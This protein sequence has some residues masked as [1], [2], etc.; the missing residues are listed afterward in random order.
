MNTR[1]SSLYPIQSLLVGALALA[2]TASA[3]SLGEA[4]R[5]QRAKKSSQA[6]ATRVYTN[7]DLRREGGLSTTS[8]EA[9]S[10]AKEGGKAVLSEDEARKAAAEQERG[11]REKAAKLRD[12]LALE[13]KKLADLQRQWNLGRQQE[14]ERQ[15][16]A[17]EA[18]KRALADLEEE[19]RKKSLSPGWAR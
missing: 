5:Q 8:L 3:Q 13:E 11:Y 16:T 1:L 6:R 10:K 12:A 2:V 7:D 14:V 15:T 18:A 9:D 17:V 19:L 4:A